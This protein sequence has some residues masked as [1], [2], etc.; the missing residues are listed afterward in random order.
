MPG[1]E[2]QRRRRAAGEPNV[3]LV[4]GRR[5]VIPQFSDEEVRYL[6]ERR[7]VAYDVDLSEKIGGCN[8][9]QTRIDGPRRP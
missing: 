6:N 2:K 1:D 7:R 9:R 3:T 8:E 5:I 4:T